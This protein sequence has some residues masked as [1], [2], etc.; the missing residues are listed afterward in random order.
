MDRKEAGVKE[1]TIRGHGE[2]HPGRWQVLSHGQ[3]PRTSVSK[4]PRIDDHDS[5]DDAERRSIN[6]IMNLLA[7]AFQTTII[8]IQVV[9]NG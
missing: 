3:S 5:S 9:P 4:W 6:L 8:L 2:N 1:R 7:Q